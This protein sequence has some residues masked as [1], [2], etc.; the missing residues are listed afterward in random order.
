MIEKELGAVAG[1]DRLQSGERLWPWRALTRMPLLNRCHWKRSL[2]A[3]DVILLSSSGVVA[4]LLPNRFS[5]HNSLHTDITVVP[6][7]KL[8][9]TMTE[10]I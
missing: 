6:H 2:S 8:F 7:S 4:K 10:D 5:E 1:A 9:S 3:D